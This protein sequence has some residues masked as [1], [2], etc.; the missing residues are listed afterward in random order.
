MINLIIPLGGKGER[1]SKCGYVCPKSL[2][3]VMGKELICWMIDHLDIQNVKTIY[4]P[5]HY[6]LEKYRFEDFLRSKYPNLSFVFLC[7]TKETSGASESIFVMFNKIK[8]EDRDYPFLCVD[9]DNFFLCNII[10]L[11][12]KSLNKNIV[13]CIEDVSPQECFSFIRVNS[14]NRIE[15]IKEKKRISNL[16]NVGCYGFESGYY[17]Y[18]ACQKIMMNEKYHQKGEP[19]LSGIVQL[20]LDEGHVFSSIQILRD[21]WICLGTPFHIKMFC[22]N[23]PRHQ[24]MNTS[25]DL[26]IPIYRFC[27]DLD[28]TLVTHPKVP[29]DY[30]TVEP[31]SST[32]SILKYLKRIGHTIIIYTARRMK[33]HNGNVNKVICDIG[34]IT[35]DTLEKY[36]IPYDELIFGKPYAHFYIDDLAVNS[37][38]DIEKE[39]GFY[40]TTISPRDFHNIETSLDTITKRGENLKSEIEWYLKMPKNIKDIFPIMFKYDSEGKW[41]EMERIHGLTVSKIYLDGELTKDTLLSILGTLDRIHSSSSSEIDDISIYSNYRT[42]LN[43]R[44]LNYDYSI[45]EDNKKYYEF[46][47]HHLEQY[48]FKNLGRK[49]IIHGDPVFTNILINCYGKIKMIDVRGKLMNQNSLY[50]DF[51]YD[52]SK[53]YQSLIGYDEILLDRRLDCKYKNDMLQVFEDYIETKFGQERLKWIKLITMSLLFT[54]IPL[55]SDSIKNKKYYE[56]MIKIYRNY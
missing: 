34:R 39:L 33:T 20:M 18:D 29:G 47:N 46:L 23:I 8:H 22:N 42:K 13:F 14:E 43:K 25:I 3:K 6:N 5:Y 28:N 15:E 49:T 7:L 51:L 17:L 45:F 10:D 55:H 41:Y 48:E 11:Y 9:G 26:K 16:V 56:L 21:Q 40:E 1:F 50:G 37:F 19:Y 4:I 35:F 52:Y 38:S 54:L 2:V 32:I 27:F 31:I 12:Q 53:I 44:Y 24:A 36:D 30:S